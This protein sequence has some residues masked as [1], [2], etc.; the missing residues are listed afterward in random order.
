MA[1]DKKEMGFL[2]HLEE[3]RRRLF[4]SVIAVVVGIIVIVCFDDFVINDLIIGPKNMDFV[5]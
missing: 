2:D 4:W 1:D 3:L 5:T